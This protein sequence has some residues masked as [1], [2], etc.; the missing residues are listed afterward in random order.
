MSM[1][2]LALAISLFLYHDFCFPW[3]RVYV[4]PLASDIGPKCALDRKMS[5]VGTG[6]SNWHKSIEWEANGMEIIRNVIEAT[7]PRKSQSHSPQSEPQLIYFS[8]AYHWMC[9]NLCK[10]VFWCF[11]HWNIKHH[12]LR[13]PAVK[14]E[15]FLSVRFAVVT[16]CS[17]H[18][19]KI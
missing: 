18:E 19:F 12:T 1:T 13:P 14:L 2:T 5:G 16:A 9:W 17:L 10:F 15:L 6:R 11:P 3:Q 4:T 7:M 8:S